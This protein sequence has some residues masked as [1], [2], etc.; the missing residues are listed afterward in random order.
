[1][2]TWTKLRA[3]LRR[4]KQDLD[5]AVGELQDRA[6]AALDRKERELGS[7]PAERLAIEQDRARSLDDEFEAV[8]RRIQDGDRP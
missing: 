8:R 6:H 2:T 1:M 4:E 5:E 7:T 3:A